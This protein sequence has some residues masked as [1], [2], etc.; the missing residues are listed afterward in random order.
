MSP[1]PFISAPW[2]YTR[3]I[4]VITIS[5]DSKKWLLMTLKYFEEKLAISYHLTILQDHILH[6]RETNVEQKR[7]DCKNDEKKI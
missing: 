2:K 3:P 1:P 5:G 4:Q 7:A 6:H